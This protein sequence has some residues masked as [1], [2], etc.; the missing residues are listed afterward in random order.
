MPPEGIRRWLFQTDCSSPA[1]Y[2]WRW[3]SN[4]P[5]FPGEP[6]ALAEMQRWLAHYQAAGIKR[7]SSG[8]TILQQCDPGGDWIPTESRGAENIEA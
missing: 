3:I 4:D 6:A 8:F 7:I 2:A 5:R 1:D